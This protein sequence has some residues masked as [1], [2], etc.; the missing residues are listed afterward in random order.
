MTFVAFAE[1]S[2]QLVPDGT[3]FLHIA[4]ILLMVFVLNATLFKPINRILEERERRTRGRSG[5]AQDILRRVEEKVTQYE[6]TLRETRAEGYRL[7]EQER[8]TAMTERQ[9]R[10]S[11]IRDELSSSIAE[12]KEAI[13]DQVSAARGTLQQEARRLAAEISSQILQRPISGPV[14]ESLGSNV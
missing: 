7:M 11:A 1:N 6:R 14:A 4:I 13:H 2:I 9:A 12:E 5:E 10:L 8:S 3:L